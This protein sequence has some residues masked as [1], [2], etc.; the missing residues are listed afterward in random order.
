MTEDKVPLTWIGADAVLE[1]VAAEP[2]RIV[3]RIQ[4]ITAWGITALVLID[5]PVF[6]ERTSPMSNPTKRKLAAKFFP[7]HSV[8][9]IRVLD[10]EEVPLP[11][12]AD[13]S[14]A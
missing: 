5:V 3:T 12:E 2:Y 14:D 1:L 6:E 4:D 8:H 9:A 11:V 7:W 13:L 10:H